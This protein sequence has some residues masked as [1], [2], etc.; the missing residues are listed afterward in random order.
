MNIISVS[1]NGTVT[2]NT[3]AV[4]ATLKVVTDDGANEGVSICSFSPTGEPNSYVSMFETNSVEHSQ[5]LD[6]TTGNYNYKIRC[7][8]YGGNAAEA[9]ISFSAIVDTL[10][11][12]ITRAYRDSSNDALKIVTNEDSSCS[13]SLNSCNFNFDEGIALLYISQSNKK[14]HYAEWKPNVAYY[15]KCR[16]IFENEPGP[17]TCSLVASATNIR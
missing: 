15:I 3:N 17:N 14:S 5:R 12:L 7:V 10:S 13:Y 11:P 6:L 8:D 4:R 2:G 16:D 9:E 1:P